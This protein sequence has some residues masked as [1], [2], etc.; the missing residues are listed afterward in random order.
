MAFN[1]ILKCEDEFNDNDFIIFFDQDSTIE[2]D[3][4]TSLAKEYE[5]LES[6]NVNMGCLAPVF[7]NTSNGTIEIPK[8]KERITD[9][10]F[11]VASVITSSLLCRYSSIKEVSFWNEDVFLDMAD[12]DFSWRIRKVGKAIVMTDSVTLRHSLGT[13][14]KKVGPIKIRVGSAFREYYQTRDCLYLLFR[15]Y[16]PF[17]FR[18]R[19]IA[20]LTIRPIIH[21]L[22]LNDRKV[23]LQYIIKGFKDFL[24]KKHGA[25]KF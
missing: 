9:N 7:F 10:S 21:L 15:S 6:N 13:G 19:F 11:K 5:L 20:Q 3:H 17:K 1:R 14:E 22:F 8:M 18:I 23:R 12:W 2:K 24:T 25:L 4:I 16:T